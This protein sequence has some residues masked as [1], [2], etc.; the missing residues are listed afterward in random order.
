MAVS[1]VSVGVGVGVSAGVG[2]SVIVG[3][4][5]GLAV[6]VALGSI[7]GLGV[8]LGSRVSVGVLTLPSPHFGERTPPDGLQINVL[9][10]CLG[11]QLIHGAIQTI[12]LSR[13]PEKEILIWRDSSVAITS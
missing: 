12:P 5:L 7:V 9:A 1:G 11:A 2:V 13:F 6:F 8:S 4:G 10:F 3:D